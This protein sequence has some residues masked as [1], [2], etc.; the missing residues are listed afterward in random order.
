MTAERQVHG[1]YQGVPWRSHEIS[2]IEA[3]S[4]AVFAL[5][6]TLLIVALEVPET[7]AE[8]WTKM[9][10]LPAFALSF[11]MLFYLWRSQHIFFRRYGLQD[12]FTTVLNGA[13]LFLVLFYMYPLKFLCTLVV[14]EFTG[15]GGAVHLADGSSAP[16]LANAAEA[17]TMMIVYD[18]G[19]AAIFGIFALLYWRVWFR[20]TEL[21]LSHEETFDA[22]ESAEANLIMVSAAFLSLAVLFLSGSASW[23]G[24]S[25]LSISVARTI[26]GWLRGR[27]RRKQFSR[28]Q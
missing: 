9:H 5:A 10:G 11:A 21:A 1:T 4:D 13:L 3:L 6:I 19:F 24:L 17:R 22:W 25:Y 15:G 20:R 12:A 7:F 28:Y 26:H 2:R 14:S 8:L 27:Q 23:S 18:L 16:M